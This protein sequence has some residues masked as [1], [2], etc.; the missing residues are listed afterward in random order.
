MVETHVFVA[1]DSQEALHSLKT[2][3]DDIIIP[4][5][6]RAERNTERDK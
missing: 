2:R 5:L 3:R 4:D 1:K 6:E